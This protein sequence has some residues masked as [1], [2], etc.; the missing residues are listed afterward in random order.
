MLW[1]LLRSLVCY[2]LKAVEWVRDYS[3]LEHARSIGVA[4]A[5]LITIRSILSN[6]SID[7]FSVNARR[8]RTRV[9]VFL[10]IRRQPKLRRHE[11]R[12]GSG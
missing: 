5:S 6:L 7:R 11:R 1:K 12:G 2:A 3:V 8:V 4:A 9:S 10:S